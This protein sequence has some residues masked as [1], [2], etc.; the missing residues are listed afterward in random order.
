MKQ[1]AVLITCFN[2][3]EKTLACLKDI[4]AQE[5]PEDC[6]I[7]IYIVDGGSTDG[8]PQVIKKTYPNVN[9]KVCQGLYWAGGMRAAWEEAVHNKEYNFFWLLNDDTH[10]YTNCLTECLKADDYATQT[11]GKEGIY[12]GS[13]LNPATK[14][15]SYG[16]R[17]LI[18]PRK[19]ASISIIPNNKTYQLCELGNANIML[20]SRFAYEKIDGFSTLY[21]HGIADYDYTL[22]AVRANIPVI[23]LPSFV[24]ECEDDH[25]NNWCPQSMPLKKRINYLYSPKGL[26]Y[27]EYLAYV[28]EFFPKEVFSQKCKLWMKT[29]FPI[30]WKYF[31]K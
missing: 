18:S 24:G 5:K 30:I 15:F 26:A 12:V 2:R 20:V 8:T 1:I 14:K 16:G 27:K 22:R 23:V 19:S 25:G 3:K 31:K 29:L 6:N 10:L 9:L 21:T 13:T 17:K 7:D 28:K 11:Y 4:Y